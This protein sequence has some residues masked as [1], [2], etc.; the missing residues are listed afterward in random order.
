VTNFTSIETWINGFSLT[1]SGNRAREVGQAISSGR[2]YDTS[3][4]PVGIQ[5][6]WEMCFY[7]NTNYITSVLFEGR[8]FI[9][10]GRSLYDDESGTLDRLYEE[11]V[12]RTLPAKDR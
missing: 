5:W 2:Y 7:N 11:V 4:S 3:Y 12:Q 10:D 8:L 6:E 9:G 1:L